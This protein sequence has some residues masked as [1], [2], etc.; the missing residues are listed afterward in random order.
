MDIAD[1]NVE[2]LIKENKQFL[3]KNKIITSLQERFKSDRGDVSTINVNKVALS[4]GDDKKIQTLDC[5][6]LSLMKRVKA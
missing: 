6:K 5:L 4:S 1:Y 2:E 3:K